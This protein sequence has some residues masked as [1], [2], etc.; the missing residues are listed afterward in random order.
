MQK[1]PPFALTERQNPRVTNLASYQLLWY[2]R[3]TPPVRFLEVYNPAC[4]A[5]KVWYP[6][7]T[8]HGSLVFTKWW[9]LQSTCEGHVERGQELIRKHAEA[10]V[11]GKDLHSWLFLISAAI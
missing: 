6:T 10:T 5:L 7:K 1:H 9:L 11:R 3:C 8:G 2:F 4:S